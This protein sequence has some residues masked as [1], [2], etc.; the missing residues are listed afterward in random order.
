ML[1]NILVFILLIQAFP[2]KSIRHI[3]FMNK[4]PQTL[5]VGAF[6]V[7]LPSVTGWEMK[8]GA[9]FDM[10]IPA[11][12]AAARFWARTDCSWINGKFVCLTGDCGTPSNN[13]GI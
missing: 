6:A 7:P 11:N 3:K 9:Q 10:A 5:W 1:R 13:F 2:W 8:P 12:T 4:C